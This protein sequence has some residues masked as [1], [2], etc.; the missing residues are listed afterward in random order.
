M[1]YQKGNGWWI[2]L[3]CL[4]VH[5]QPSPTCH[6]PLP[7][8]WQVHNWIWLW[9]LALE[10]GVFLISI[11]ISLS[12]MISISLCLR[13]SKCKIWLLRTC[14]RSLRWW[15]AGNKA[16]Q[17]PPRLPRL[18]LMGN[19]WEGG[20]CT[21]RWL[22]QVQK[23]FVIS[24]WQ[25]QSCPFFIQISNFILKWQVDNWFAQDDWEHLSLI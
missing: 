11:C 3:D 17:F 14:K 13:S 12:N 10:E 15:Q 7:P 9:W 25:G 19:N 21:C 5:L 4:R 8:K 23:D 6:R 18:P 1:D 20:E 22:H 2:G 16:L 24:G